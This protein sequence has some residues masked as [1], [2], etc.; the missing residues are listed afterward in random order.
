M[1][2]RRWRIEPTGDPM[3]EPIKPPFTAASAKA[4]SMAP[5]TRLVLLVL[6]NIYLL[7][8]NQT[9]QDCTL[10]VHPIFRFIKDDGMFAVHDF[11]GDFFATMSR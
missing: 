10:S 3:T 4:P 9:R 11:I 2:A 6:L 7:L 5:L 8:A 1:R